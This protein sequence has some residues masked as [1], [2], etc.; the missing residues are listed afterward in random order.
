[1][2][3]VKKYL[4]LILGLAMFFVKLI[5]SRDNFVSHLLVIILLGFVFICSQNKSLS[6]FKKFSRC[7]SKGMLA[8]LFYVLILLIV[9]SI[10]NSSSNFTSTNFLNHVAEFL[11]TAISQL[12]VCLVISIMCSV[13]VPIFF[14][15]KVE[16]RE[17][18]LDM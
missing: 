12:I 2:Q 4:I 3:F 16:D 18:I 14:I 15:T 9:K 11:P 8:S 10:I 17:D 6:Y 1:M 13:I 7:L 5:N